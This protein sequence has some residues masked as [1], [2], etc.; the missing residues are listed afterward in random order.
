MPLVIPAARGSSSVT[1]TEIP[2][3]IE[4]GQED[5]AEENAYL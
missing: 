4:E 2:A 1:A 5:V 3:P